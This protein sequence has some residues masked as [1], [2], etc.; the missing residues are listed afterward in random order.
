MQ[1]FGHLV[2]CV[3]NTGQTGP[4]VRHFDFFEED[5][6]PFATNF[7]VGRLSRLSGDKRLPETRLRDT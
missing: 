2:L 6:R 1:R 4:F 5:K 3:A 7:F